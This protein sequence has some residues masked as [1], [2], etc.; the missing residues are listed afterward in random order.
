[1][2]LERSTSTV[3]TGFASKVSEGEAAAV[4]ALAAERRNVYIETSSSLS[5]RQAIK[6]W[7]PKL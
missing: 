4:L 6:I 1:M 5:F 7:D 2:D 3:L